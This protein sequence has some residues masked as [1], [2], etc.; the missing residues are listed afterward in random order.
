[1]ATSE[2]RSLLA[3]IS[4]WLKFRGKHAGYW[5]FLF[6]RGSGVVLVAYLYLHLYE[7]RLLLV[8]SVAYEGFLRLVLSPIFLPFDMLLFAVGIYHGAN[9]LK[10]AINEFG[11]GIN[12]SKSLLVLMLIIGVIVWAY[13]SYAVAEFS[14]GT[15]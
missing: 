14:L 6:Q 4:Q 5:A 2:L 13:A 7:L 1:M 11:Y 10:T 3:S 15:P 12:H 9:G 8:G